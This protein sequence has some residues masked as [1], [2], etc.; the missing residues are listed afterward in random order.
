MIVYS[1]DNQVF[2]QDTREIFNPPPGY[3]AGQSVTAQHGNLDI[4]CIFGGAGFNDLI[5]VAP[6]G[7]GQTFTPTAN[8]IVAVEIE[9]TQLQLVSVSPI[10]KIRNGLNGPV[11]GST[12][13]HTGLPGVGNTALVHF[14][15]PAL[16]PLT[17]GTQYHIDP[18]VNAADAGSLVWV[19]RTGDP[20][21]G[22]GTVQVGFQ[23]TNEERNYRTFF[24][25]TTVGGEFIGVDSTALLLAG[26]QANASWMIPV[27]VSGIGFAIVIARKF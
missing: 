6:G 10:V 24:D 1:L 27:I 9:I 26:T 19:S 7:N 8:N 23:F 14:D 4:A 18:E 5:L 11:I 12:N 16:I 13:I 15:F 21:P 3:V 25:L 2:A 20:C 17:P 22:G